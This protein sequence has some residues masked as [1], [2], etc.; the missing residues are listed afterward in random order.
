MLGIV[1]NTSDISFGLLSFS[2]TF[3]FTHRKEWVPEE[4]GG[5]GSGEVHE[6]LDAGPGVAGHVDDPP[7]AGGAQLPHRLHRDPG[8]RGV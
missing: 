6:V 1:I 5:G 7:D 4:C 3:I 8:P 2:N